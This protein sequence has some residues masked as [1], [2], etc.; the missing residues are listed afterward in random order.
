M[1]KLFLSKICCLQIILNIILDIILNIIL[2]NFT[3]YKTIKTLIF[4]FY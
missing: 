1:Y 3:N 2:L 4:N